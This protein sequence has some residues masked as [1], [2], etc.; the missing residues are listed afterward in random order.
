MLNKKKKGTAAA[1]PF[2][3]R[4]K[5]MK[6]LAVG[7]IVGEN[8][9]KKL[10]EE[11]PKIKKERSID[12][13]IV[14]G[15]N[16]AGGMGITHKLFNQIIEAGANVVTLGNHTWSKKDIFNF[17]DDEKILRPAN[18][19]GNVPGKGYNIYDCNNKKI[20]VISL[21]GR[22]NMG[23]LSENPFLEA[24]KIISQI[25]NQV[26]IIIVDFHAEASAEKIAMKNYLN[27][28]V[29][30]VFGTHTHVQTADEEITSKGTGYIT[31]I[32][33][34]GPKDSVIGMDKKASIKRFVTALPEKYK[35]AEGECKLNSC[36]F[37]LDDETCRVSK[38][39]RIN[40]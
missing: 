2:K 16:V 28:R 6:I 38:I 37:E 10:R 5:L 35:L 33:M 40:L 39:T 12:F 32:G 13:I 29:N 36:L 19:P 11:L 21:L 7:D 4:K 14:N 8:G 25:K 20:A 27:G 24:D 26:D 34:T 22:T 23:I 1:V 31:D 17:I 15:E 9:L 3:E 30:I 18:Y